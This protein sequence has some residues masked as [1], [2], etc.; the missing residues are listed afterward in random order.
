[1][2]E[3]EIIKINSKKKY[4]EVQK[5]LLAKGYKWIDGFGE[6]YDLFKYTINGFFEIVIVVHHQNKTFEWRFK[7]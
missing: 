4:D 3:E 5:D 1:M 7:E 6:Y 2:A